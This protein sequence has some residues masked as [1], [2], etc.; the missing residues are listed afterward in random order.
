MSAEGRRRL[1]WRGVKSVLA[2][3]LVGGLL[4]AGIAVAATLRGSSKQLTNAAETT[5]VKEVVLITDGV[6]DHK[7]LIR[8]LALPKNASLMQLDLYQLRARVM[9]SGQVKTATLTRN[10]PATLTVSLS[11]QSPVARLKAQLGPS[12]PRT[13]LVA[14][15]GT[16]FDGIG[17]DPAMVTTLPWLD[18]VKLSRMGDGLAPIGGMDAVAD[19]LA[20]AKLEADHLYRTWQVV[21]LARLE[22]D[23]EIEV[24]A[25]EVEKIIFGTQEDFFRQ[26]AR[27]DALLDL[28]R[29]QTAQ[30]LRE[31]NLAIGA[32]VP[33]AFTDPALNPT[34]PPAKPGTSRTTAATAPAAGNPLPN[35][36]RKSKP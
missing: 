8:T 18:G 36:Q 2:M 35:L 19:L 21:S 5:P 26:L 6:L 29:A 3:A 13:L 34:P 9:A 15:D 11:E 1:V 31:V 24:R 10:F 22:S 7:W 33:V 16:V 23:G 27:L 32:Q 12:E 20:K 30:P 4:W 14:R 25:Q 17:F 28:A